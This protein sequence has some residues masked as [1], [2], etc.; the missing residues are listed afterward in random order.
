[1]GRYTVGRQI[2]GWMG[3]HGMDVVVSGQGSRG[4]TTGPP[5]TILRSILGA[6]ERGN[7]EEPVPLLSSPS[8]PSF[9]TPSPSP[10]PLSLASRAARVGLVWWT[11]EAPPGLEIRQ[12]SSPLGDPWP[13][14]CPGCKRGLM[15]PCRKMVWAG[16][17]LESRSQ[18]A[19][20]T[21]QGVPSPAIGPV[22]GSGVQ[23]SRPQ[24]DPKLFSKHSHSATGQEQAQERQEHDDLSGPMI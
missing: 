24:R 8:L 4:Q 20:P 2:H 14:S 16:L 11:W 12:I 23:P 21:G 6:R 7:Q 15:C 5:L 22:G 9:L 10:L 19:K 1:M 17:G 3:S 18:G 13:R